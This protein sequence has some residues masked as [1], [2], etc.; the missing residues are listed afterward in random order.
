MPP[1]LNARWNEG[2]FVCTEGKGLL[3]GEQRKTGDDD[4]DATGR[5]GRALNFRFTVKKQKSQL[6]WRVAW[7]G[8]SVGCDLLGLRLAGGG[9][10]AR[11]GGALGLGGLAV[12]LLQIR[13]NDARNEL[14]LPVIVEFD[15]RLVFV[16]RH[17]GA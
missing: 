14:F 8:Q 7:T 3:E 13:D 11:A 12:A 6:L 10:F 4:G 16:A 2:E 9:F 17:H 15:H 5:A 1:G